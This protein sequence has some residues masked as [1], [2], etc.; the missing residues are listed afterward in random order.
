MAHKGKESSD[1]SFNPD[2]L[3]EAYTNSSAYQKI[4]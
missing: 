1:V 3:A 2:D 4:T